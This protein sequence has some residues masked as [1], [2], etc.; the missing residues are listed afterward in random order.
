MTANRFTFKLSKFRI[1]ITLIMLINEASGGCQSLDSS[2]SPSR[3][4]KTQKNRNGRCGDRVGHSAPG[5]PEGVRQV[6]HPHR[7][8]VVH[9]PTGR[10][11]AIQPRHSGRRCPARHL[12]PGARSRATRGRTVR[13]APPAREAP[14][15]RHLP[16][17]RR[18]RDCPQRHSRR[19]DRSSGGSCGRDVEDAGVRSCS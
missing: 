7:R 4:V 6:Q 16:T 8:P 10:A 2:A 11:T 12:V 9:D 13:R 15:R 5:S 3:R 1:L 19:Q 18:D 14:G 17:M